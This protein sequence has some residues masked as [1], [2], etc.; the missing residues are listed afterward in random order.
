MPQHS[1]DPDI[2]TPLYDRFDMATGVLASQ[3]CKGQKQF[4]VQWAPTPCR[5]RH[6]PLH[7]ELGY[8]VHCTAPY[9]GNQ[10]DDAGEETSLVTWEPKWEAADSFCHPDHPEQVKLAAE[11]AEDCDELDTINLARDN[12][13]RQDAHKSNLDTQGT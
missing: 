4:L 3:W 1:T 2:V 13:R 5:V 8:K 10:L 7:V 12:H 11:F 6:I 9:T